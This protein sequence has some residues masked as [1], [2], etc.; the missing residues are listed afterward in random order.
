[1]HPPRSKSAFELRFNS[2][3]QSFE[4]ANLYS[5]PSATPRANPLCEIPFET[6]RNRTWPSEKIPGGQGLGGVSWLA[7]KPSCGEDNNPGSRHT[8]NS[9][10]TD[11]A[12]LLL[13]IMSA[14]FRLSNCSKPSPLLR[15]LNCSQLFQQTLAV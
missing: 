6:Q 9:K 3:M 2:A 15:S 5:Q 14:L 12:R 4:E 8:I 10:L 1:M 7:G 13:L 11:I